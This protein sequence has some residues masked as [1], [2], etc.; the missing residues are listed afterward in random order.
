VLG[1][2]SIDLDGDTASGECVWAAVSGSGDGA[3]GILVGRHVDEL[4]R[5]DGRWRFAR[6]VGHIDVGALG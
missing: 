3:P 5:E 4:V 2:P 1:S 6:R